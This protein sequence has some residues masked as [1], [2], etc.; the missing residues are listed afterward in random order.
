MEH[1]SPPGAGF[2]TAT[3]QTPIMKKHGILSLLVA[4]ACICLTNPAIAADK[5]GQSPADGGRLIVG[6]TANFG[7]IT[8]ILLS[9]DGKQVAQIP[10]GQKYD[11]YLSPGHHEISGTISPNFGHSPPSKHTIDVQAG[12]TY[13][14]TAT[15]K[16]DDMVLVRNK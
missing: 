1:N 16:A 3:K 11:G 2:S 12:Q 14:F 5:K 8:T 7:G 15:W 6:R 13:S 10:R 4:I 9:V